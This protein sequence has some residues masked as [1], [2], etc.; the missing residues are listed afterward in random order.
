[1]IS[2]ELFTLKCDLHAH[3]T[4]SDGSD[5]PEE[6]AEKGAMAGLSALALTD[7]NSVKGLP[8]FLSSDVGGRV[9]L[10]GGIEFST[11]Y[12]KTELHIIALGVLPEHYEV[13]TE[14]VDKMLEGKRRANE[15]LIERLLA[16]GYNIDT[17][18]M[19]E[20]CLGDINR[21]HIATELVRCGYATDRSD[22]FRRILNK[23]GKFYI[24]PKR[25]DVFETIS[26]IKSL[27][28]AAI[29]CHPLLNL[30]RDE[31]EVFLPQAIESGLDAMECIYSEY[32]DA[33]TEYSLQLCK[34]HGILVS[35]GSDYHGRNKPTISLGVG[36]GNLD[37]P[38]S[39]YLDIK[40][41]I[42]H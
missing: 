37:I 7:H 33:D 30:T 22:A 5:T 32:S 20:G 39:I 31:L 34:S 36:E 40:E 2:K 17:V 29:L 1:M 25:L 41:R 11:D 10:I 6:L 9:E 13:I 38:L 18:R 16:A 15:E 4:Y 27:G 42:K 14:Q 28:L 8:E 3:S 21:A 24:E 12:G 26:F 23:G 19:R 35:G